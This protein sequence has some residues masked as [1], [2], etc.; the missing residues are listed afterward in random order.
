V[1]FYA[2][3]N[4][5]AVSLF[6]GRPYGVK[7]AGGGNAIYVGSTSLKTGRGQYEAVV[8]GAASVVAGDLV[9]TSGAFSGERTRIKVLTTTWEW[10][11]QTVDGYTYRVFGARAIKTN[12]S[13]AAGHGDS[14]G[15]V[16][17]SVKGG[18]EAV[19]IISST[20]FPGH[21]AA[22]TGVLL[23]RGCYWDFNFSLM[24][25]TATSIETEMNLAVNTGK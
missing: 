16:F 25:G 5:D 15:P 1:T 18:V 17:I 22:C 24:T 11:G 23:N 19:G 21:R 10:P 7:G 14:G 8:R 20:S 6:T 4:N 9:S 13:N 12:H 3:P 2:A